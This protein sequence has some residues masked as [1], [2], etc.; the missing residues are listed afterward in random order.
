MSIED[1]DGTFVVVVNEDGQYSVWPEGRDIPAGYKSTGKRGK[2]KE[3]LDNIEENWTNDR[4]KGPRQKKKQQS[5]D[6]E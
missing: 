5:E 2:K 6:G 3:C 4:P 1:E